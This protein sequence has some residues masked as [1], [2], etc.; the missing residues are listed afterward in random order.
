MK[1]GWIVERAVPGR[2][3]EIAD[4]I[5]RSL[6]ARLRPLTIWESPGA[7]LYVESL[8]SNARPGEGHRFYLLR[9]DNSA[10]GVAALR[11]LDG[12]AFLNHLYVA[13]AFQ[14]C[15]LGANL[16]HAALRDYLS[17]HRARQLALDVF[18]DTAVE[19]WYDRLGL[20]ERDRR[21]WWLSEPLSAPAR[22]TPPSVVT[23]GWG[24]STFLLHTAGGPRYE[25]GLLYT[26]YFRLT[27]PRAAVDAQ[28][29]NALARIDPGRRL[30]LIASHAPPTTWTQ[31]AVSRRLASDAASVLAALA[32]RTGKAHAA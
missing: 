2:G 28:L 6:A 18:A 27:D 4:L 19:D 10:C 15:G 12:A 9:R 32:E 31:V 11:R 30:L 7:E 3:A 24:F 22:R 21:G 23:T 20:C 14:G 8:L 25:I 26:P 29:H 13:P 1:N 5:R 16:F 17:R